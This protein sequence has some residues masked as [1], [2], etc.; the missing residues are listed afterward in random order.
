MRRDETDPASTRRPSPPQR[1][2]PPPLL[3]LALPARRPGA[4]G[5][6]VEVVVEGRAVPAAEV[7]DLQVDL[8]PGLL[9]KHPLQVALGGLD[10]L[11][12]RQAPAGGQTVDVGVY[13]KGRQPEGL[14]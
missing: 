10:V 5:A 11:A 7:D 13:R 8:A 4:D 12:A 14:V 6:R 2:V 3:L 1:Q 9:G